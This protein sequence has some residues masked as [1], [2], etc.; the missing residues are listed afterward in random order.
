[1]KKI[2]TALCLCTAFAAQAQT[3]ENQFSRSLH[4]V[5]NDISQRFQVRFR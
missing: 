3:F 2:A 1:M 5:L 4:D